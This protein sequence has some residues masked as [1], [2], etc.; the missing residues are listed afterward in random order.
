MKDTRYTPHCA[1]G[2]SMLIAAI[3]F[4]ML[5]FLMIGTMLPSY[6]TDY[7]TSV[8]NR[9]YSAAF[10]LAE[11]GVEEAIW[12]A[13]NNRWDVNSWNGDGSW[14]LVTDAQGNS[15]YCQRVQFPGVTFGGGYTGYAKVAVGQPSSGQNLELYSQ[16]VILDGSGNEV[17]TRVIKVDADELRP[18][19]GFVAKDSIDLGAGTTLG[20]V[21]TDDYATIALALSNRT[22]DSKVG[23]PSTSNGSI[24]LGNS[25]SKATANITPFEIGSV[26]TG[27][28]VFSD[29]V[30]Y[31]GNIL[32]QE[33]NFSASFPPISHPSASG[34]NGPSAF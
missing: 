30:S 7:R 14:Q 24:K 33:T 1:R 18:F 10:S 4:A 3:I 6:V 32:N 9:L 23:S 11:A 12:S 13:Y 8:R 26:M 16:G 22:S 27:A 25:N 29:A 20:S 28:N 15:Y 19:M 17:L 34:N 21:N 2:G 31:N 5:A